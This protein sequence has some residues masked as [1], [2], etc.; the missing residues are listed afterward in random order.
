M[1]ASAGAGATGPGVTSAAYNAESYRNIDWLASNV[2][3]PLNFNLYFIF[4]HGE[5]IPDGMTTPVEM[6]VPPNTLVIQTGGGGRVGCITWSTLDKT[7]YPLFRPS[8]LVTTFSRFTGHHHDRM[9]EVYRT[10]LY[11]TPTEIALNKRIL[12]DTTDVDDPKGTRWGVFK[13]AYVKDLFRLTEQSGFTNRIRDA[14][15]RGE[16][17]TQSDLAWLISFHDPTKTNILFFINCAV[18][19]K[20]YSADAYR[21]S[22]EVADRNTH[23]GIG[24]SANVLPGPNRPL[25]SRRGY[26]FPTA[27]NK[28]SHTPA[29]MYAAVNRALRTMPAPASMMSPEPRL[30]ATETEGICDCITSFCSSCFTSVKSLLKHD[31][32]SRRRRARRRGTRRRTTRRLLR[33]LKARHTAGNL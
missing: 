13:V 22:L 26:T 7:F 12:L 19:P 1:S 18:A 32:G 25:P 28:I 5:L 14:T 31:G 16:I 4:S 3:T 17:F 11:N 24:T 20:K 9:D 2:L 23:F 30:P 29:L 6:V 8:N 15:Q 27:S 33:K 21:H 10:L